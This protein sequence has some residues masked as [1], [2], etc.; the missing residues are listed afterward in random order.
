M[1]GIGKCIPSSWHGFVRT[2]S[3]KDRKGMMNKYPS[4]PRYPSDASLHFWLERPFSAVDKYVFTAPT[5][6]M[7]R[8]PTW[9]ESANSNP[10]ATHTHVFSFPWFKNA[11]ET[12]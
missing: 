1:H 9:R 11:V 3:R 7:L 5:K 6:I 8:T 12:C 10:I 4:I 2:V